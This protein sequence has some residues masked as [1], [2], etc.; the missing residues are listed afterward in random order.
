MFNKYVEFIKALFESVFSKGGESV[1]FLDYIYVILFTLALIAVFA[2]CVVVLIYSVK[3]PIFVYKRITHKTQ[4]KI[5]ELDEKIAKPTEDVDGK[6]I[7]TE[8]EEL[9]HS[10][11]K[12][13]CCFVAGVVFL[14]I[15]IL[16]PTLLF[17]ASFIKS[18]F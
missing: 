2:A 4:A 13:I 8:R 18:W 5:N 7:F 12:R 11:T 1:S 17:V 3:L 10:L 15:P 9:Q 14:Y 16:I 6:A